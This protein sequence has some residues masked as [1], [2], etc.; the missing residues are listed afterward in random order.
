MCKVSEEM[1]FAFCLSFL[2]WLVEGTLYILRDCWS[3]LVA[4]QVKD[5]GLSLLQHGLLLKCEFHPWPENLHML[6]AWPNKQNRKTVILV[7]SRRHSLKIFTVTFLFQ[8]YS[9]LL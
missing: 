6:Q 5:L 3:S 4:Q 8:K 7:L 2:Y 9:Y 1:S